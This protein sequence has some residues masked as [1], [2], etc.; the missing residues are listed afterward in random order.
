MIDLST[1]RW[2]GKR[3]TKQHSPCL[4]TI[5]G[6]CLLILSG[7]QTYCSRIEPSICYTVPVKHIKALSS[8]F[9]RLSRE[10]IRQEWGRELYIGLN[11]ANELDLYRAITAFK[12]ALLFL[13]ANQLERRQQIE[14]Y[15]FESYYLG[16]KYLDALETFD[17]SSLITVPET[18]PAFK[19]LMI[20]LFDCY[21]KTEQWEKAEKIY[22]LLCTFDPELSSELVLSVAFMQG[23]LECIKSFAEDHPQAPCLNEFVAHYETYAKSIKKARHLNA[24]LPGA[25]YYYVGQK[26]AAATSFLI[27]ALFIGA[28]YLFIKNGNYP[29]GIITASLESGWYIGGINGAG[30]AAKEYNERLY[31]TNAKEIMIQN[32]LFP[33]LMLQKS[34]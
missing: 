11:F 6:L 1:K 25:G 4:L 18:F 10:E 31:E 22:N 3:N 33:V 32:K 12:T 8:P 17:N 27:N 26:K 14:Y 20:M 15:I 23:N 7:C 21:Q 2:S 5:W 30:L 28:T 16:N 9:E 24:L 13:P 29:A 34:F 19:D